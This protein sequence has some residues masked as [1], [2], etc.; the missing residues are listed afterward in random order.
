[1]GLNLYSRDK[2]ID[3]VPKWNGNRE[4][5]DPFVIKLRFLNYNEIVAVQRQIRT[6]SAKAKNQAK[7]ED[8]LLDV[9]TQMLRD[10]IVGFEN[11]CVDGQ[12]IETVDQFMD[13]CIEALVEEI[14][15]AMTNI[16]KLT[17]GERKN[18]SAVSDGGSKSQTKAAPSTVPD[19]QTPT[20]SIA[21]ATTGKSLQI[22][23]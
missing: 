13:N 9:Q 20:E 2:V 10:N 6:A 21:T 23:Q 15:D 16:T 1:M 12:P 19:A 4:S 8:V 5:D 17:E 7:K 14:A 22:A 11:V 3:Y 18:L